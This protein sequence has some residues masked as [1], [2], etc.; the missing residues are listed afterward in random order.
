MKNIRRVVISL[1]I[2]AML[3]IIFY[4]ATSTI[5]KYTGYSISEKTD[6]TQEFK[7]CLNEKNIVVYVN[8]NDVSKTLKDLKTTDYL[9]GIKIFNCNEDNEF[10]NKNKIVGPFPVWE[11]N[12]NRV[13]SDISLEELQTLSEC[14]L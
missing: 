4:I 6:K 2:L 14:K 10:C 11:V 8:T 3:V 7:S 9:E 12:N 13:Y 5:T 1:L